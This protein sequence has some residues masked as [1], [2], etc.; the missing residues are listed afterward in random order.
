M[1]DVCG[2]SEPQ[3]ITQESKSRPW[4]P[5]GQYLLGGFDWARQVA[6]SPGQQNPVPMNP[7]TNE[8]LQGIIQGARDPNSPTNVSIDTL[9]GTARGDFLGGNPYYTSAYETAVRPMIEQFNSEIAP[10]IDAAFSGAGRYGS[11]LYAQAR[12]RAE[13]TLTRGLGDVATNMGYANWNDERTR[14][15]QAAGVLPSMANAPNEA[16]V[17]A[18]NAYQGQ[19]IGEQQFPWQQVAKFMNLVGGQSY[20]SNTSSTQTVPTY[21]NPVAGGLG[22][23]LGINQLFAGPTQGGLANIGNFLL[24]I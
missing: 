1:C 5:Q 12:N 21:S 14:Q 17:N 23:L 20:G 7:V 11:G 19:A 22:A 16:L 18:G 2:S 24:G 6:Q 9:T 13:D 4:Y 3:V 8:G 15:L 10:G